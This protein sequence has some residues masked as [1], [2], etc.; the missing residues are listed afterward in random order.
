M[1]SREGPRIV[2]CIS[3]L[4]GFPYL[5]ECV[6]SILSQRGEFKADLVLVDAGSTDETIEW[7]NELIN[8]YKYRRN[9]IRFDIIFTEHSGNIYECLQ[10]GFSL[11]NA[12][13][14]YYIG[15]DDRLMPEA[16]EKVR[17][18]FQS[19][20]N[21]QILTGIPANMDENGVSSYRFIPLPY[22]KLFMRNGLYGS[23][24]PVIHAESVFFR[25]N[26]WEKVN[27]VQLTSYSWAGDFFMWKSMADAG[28]RFKHIPVIL[29]ESRIHKNRKGVLFRSEYQTEVRKIAGKASIGSKISAFGWKS[30]NLIL[31]EFL[32]KKMY[33][34]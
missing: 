28:L 11:S 12:P 13:I 8:K 4:N 34:P 20:P 16:L 33:F 7:I 6:E 14:L 21:Q 23:V 5:P 32:I 30:L 1:D 24:L 9:C 17:Q 15:S 25:R 29:C 2:I 26:A 27:Q 18:Y 3:I 19:H 10:I 31:P 22:Q